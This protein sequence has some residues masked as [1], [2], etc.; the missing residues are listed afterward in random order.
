M[1]QREHDIVVSGNSLHC[2]IEYTEGSLELLGIGGNIKVS[3]IVPILVV[4]LI[5]HYP[6]T[7]LSMAVLS[8]ITLRQEGGHS[9]YRSKSLLG[10]YIK[11][12]INSL[13]LRKFRYSNRI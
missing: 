8:V 1:I 5:S 9:L 10:F 4:N 2:R 3:L 6:V 12:I 13:A 11:A 7:D